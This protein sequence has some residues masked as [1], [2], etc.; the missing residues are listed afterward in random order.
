M[1][2]I[3]CHMP[4]PQGTEVNWRLC[5]GQLLGSCCSDECSLLLWETKLAIVPRDTYEQYVA[6][7]LEQR[8]R[9]RAAEVRGLPFDE[10]ILKSPAE[11]ELERQELMR[12]LNKSEAA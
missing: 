1:N 10:P 5:N 11:Q 7:D 4:I 2:C 9:R 3:V 6:A 12:L 8:W